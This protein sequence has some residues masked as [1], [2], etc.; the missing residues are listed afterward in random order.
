MYKKIIFILNMKIIHNLNKYCYIKG[1][2][3]KEDQL[4]ESKENQLEKSYISESE[5]EP[6]EGED[7]ADDSE[8]EDES[9]KSNSLES[10]AISS[11]DVS[12]LNA[13]FN[14][15]GNSACDDAI[16]K[17]DL[18]KGP[19]GDGKASCCIYCGKFQMKLPRHLASK[20][21]NEKEVSDFLKLPKGPPKNAAIANIRK[22][23]NFL[24]NVD[25]EK[26]GGK[27]IPVRR[28][29]TEE[30]RSGENFTA[31]PKCKG[32]YTK[33]NLRHHY[34]KCT[35]KNV[36]TR[37]ILVAARTAIGRIHPVASIIMRQY[38]IPHMKEN[39]VTNCAIR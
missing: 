6:S 10:T 27:L 9:E 4:E 29:R 35:N 17:A 16:L 13:S 3:R 11:T 19:K 28:P 32:F 38:I 18:S 8:N 12:L 21:F 34:A 7:T 33:N 20:H 22:K 36:N 5:Y 26:N 25:A 30:K 23:G 14:I 2:E 24:Y 15:P 39:D 1:A 31:C 37:G